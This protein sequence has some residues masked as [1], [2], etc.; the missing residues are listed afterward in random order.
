MTRRA[1]G[2]LDIRNLPPY[3]VSST[4][5][6]STRWPSPAR[7]CRAFFF[8]ACHKGLV[9]ILRRN[10]QPRAD[11]GG[12]ER[13]ATGVLG[14]EGPELGGRGAPLPI[15]GQSGGSQNEH[16]DEGRVPDRFRR[17]GVGG[18]EFPFGIAGRHSEVR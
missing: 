16:E 2:A 8:S 18:G 1:S 4:T 15:S 17:V 9:Y 5:S 6:D 10:R 13:E 3:L 14:E 11:V 7:K 12:P